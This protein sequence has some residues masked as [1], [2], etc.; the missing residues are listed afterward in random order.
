M[1]VANCW[2]E[3]EFQRMRQRSD[4]PTSRKVI[5]EEIHLRPTQEIEFVGQ[6]FYAE[7]ERAPFLE[8]IIRAQVKEC[9]SLGVLFAGFSDVDIAISQS[10]EAEPHVTLR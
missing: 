2:A 4:T 1:D 8:I 10:R 7:G 5:A 6:V 3:L 9:V